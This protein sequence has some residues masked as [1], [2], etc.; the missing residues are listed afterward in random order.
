MYRKIIKL[1]VAVLLANA[2]YQFV[3]PYWRYIRFKDAVQDIALQAKGKPDSTVIEEVMALAARFQV[4]LERD[5]IAVSRPKD[6]THTYIDASWIEEIQFV[7]TWKYVWQFDVSAD[8]W[9]VRPLTPG[10]LR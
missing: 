6:M 9:H 4:P 7:P 8:G 2:L 1:T 10:D 5:W 3:P